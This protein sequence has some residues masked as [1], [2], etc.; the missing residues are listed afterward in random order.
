MHI[1]DPKTYGFLSLL[2]HFLA[3]LV[4]F[5]LL[6]IGSFIPFFHEFVPSGS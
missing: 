3:D 4:Y 1:V 6:P 5:S 2:P